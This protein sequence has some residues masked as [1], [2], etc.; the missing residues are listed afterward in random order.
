MLSD[1]S[2]GGMILGDCMI[3]MVANYSQKSRGLYS[4]FLY[5]KAEYIK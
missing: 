3:N 1:L 4:A 5:G 2:V